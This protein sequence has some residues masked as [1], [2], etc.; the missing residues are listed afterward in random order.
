M[1]L[2]LII[3]SIAAMALLL[4]GQY[5]ASHRQFESQLLASSRLLGVSVDRELENGRTLLGGLAMAASLQTG[6]MDAFDKAARFA[7]RGRKGWIVLT[8]DQGRQLVNTLVPRETALSRG[9]FPQDARTDLRRGRTR[10]SG[11]VTGTLLRRPVVAID[12]PVLSNGR[13]HVLSY[14]QE[15]VGFQSIFV[16]KLLPPAWIGVILDQNG[17]V[18]ARSLAPKENLGRMATPDLQRALRTSSEGIIE[19]RSLEGMPTTAGYTRSNS[20]GWTFLIAAPRREAQWAAARSMRAT[21]VSFCV[22][23]VGGLLSARWFAR[24]I[25]RD[26]D[27]LADQ[28]RRLASDKQSVAPG[29]H[30]PETAAVRDAMAAAATGLA[31]RE[32]ERDA[33]AARQATLI[34][35]LNHR[36]KNSLATVQSLARHSFLAP[37]ERRR[38]GAFEDRVVALSRAHDLLT[39]NAW[40]G[41]DLVRLVAQTLAPYGDR[42]TWS[43]PSISLNPQ[44]ALSLSLVLHELAT[45]AAKY[46]AFTTEGRVEVAWSVRPDGRCIDLSWVESGGPPATAP[47]REGFGSRL[48]RQSVE[49]ELRGV[50]TTDYAPEG[51]R[52]RFELPVSEAIRPLDAPGLQGVEPARAD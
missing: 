7:T 15:P 37:Q 27:E 11:L 31:Q 23:L 44:S 33:A 48:I 6:D 1:S 19:S 3:P 36:V 43:G 10:V 8:D 50:M 28:A 21:L 26:I 39:E 42:S 38:L 40:A 4:A 46:G 24:P 29:G 34:N 51:L 12:R 20:T 25:S 49:R 14:I 30:L 52:R 18:I 45:N 5:Q 13:L 41:A 17:R 9:G 35:E 16:P 2:C 32:A 47:T 22:L